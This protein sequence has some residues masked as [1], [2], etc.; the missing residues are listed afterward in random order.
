MASYLDSLPP[1][2]GLRAALLRSG[3]LELARVNALFSDLKIDGKNSLAELT[4]EERERLEH[5]LEGLA[6][7]PVGGPAALWSRFLDRVRGL[8]YAYALEHRPLEWDPSDAQ[9][10]LARWVERFLTP[11]ALDVSSQRRLGLLKQRVAERPLPCDEGSEV[12]YQE[13]VYLFTLTP[14]EEDLLWLFLAPSF[15]PEFGWLYDALTRGVT[16]GALPLVLAA[17]IVAMSTDP[18]VTPAAISKALSPQGTLRQSALIEASHGGETYRASSRIVRL[19]AT[20]EFLPIPDDLAGLIRL[21]QSPD[22]RAV[23]PVLKGLD[24]TLPKRLRKLF[25]QR[26]TRFLV[27]GPSGTGAFTLARVIAGFNS[28]KVATVDLEVLVA[29]PE[30]SWRAVF[31]ESKLQGALLY[32]RHVNVL[33]DKE[34]SELKRERLLTALERERSA[35]VF[36]VGP[37][38]STQLLLQLSER[39]DTISMRLELPDGDARE[40]LWRWALEEQ[41][42][43]EPDADGEEEDENEQALDL[44]ALIEGV[45]TF[46]LGVDQIVESIELGRVY[47]AQGGLEGLPPLTLEA[48]KRACQAKLGH[49]LGQVAVRIESKASWNDL[50]M[51]EDLREQIDEVLGYGRLARKVL[52]EWGFGKKLSYG[53]GLTALFSGPS[54]T[55]KTM[56]AG[57]IARELKM[58]LYRID[59][60]RMVSKYIGETEKQLAMLFEEARASG[61]ALL[62]DE[63][64][65]LFG[66]RTEVS[67]STD[68]YANLEVNFLLQQVEEHP[69]V[70][71]LTS[72]F[73]KSIDEAFLR[74]LRFRVE[75][76]RPETEERLQMWLRMLP[77]DAP[78]EDDLKLDELAETYEL[79]GGE[80]RNAVLRA[81]L[82]AA[83]EGRSLSAADFERSARAEYRQLGRLAPIKRNK[84]PGSQ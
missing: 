84:H 68:R 39:L 43:A 76:P 33:A 16:R 51:S 55:G 14:L 72:N 77:A 23:D 44:G 29:S 83:S 38:L 63:A 52:D 74:R 18:D 58:D 21:D 50:I 35:M 61:A 75:F 19:L 42:G 48:L 60:S 28:A 82:Y 10:A 80:I 1:E 69:G 62:F 31:R 54:G 22:I 3:A 34:T 25:R 30:E 17:Q 64:D 36:D 13:L 53:R 32:I 6:L 49:R 9:R 71:L 57:L 66:K 12:H 67:S 2:L 73:P 37:A 78:R 65:S 20:G 79:S 41:F 70:V 81:A 47:T 45:R 4:A 15:A 11:Q 59:L 56:V 7:D 27:H 8:V 40:A 26:K 24:P 46:P 5:E